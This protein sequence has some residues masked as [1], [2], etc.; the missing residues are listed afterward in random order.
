MQ[1]KDALIWVMRRLV[2][3]PNTVKMTM[4]LPWVPRQARRQATHSID[5]YIRAAEGGAAAL[6]HIRDLELTML[7]TYSNG[8]Q[9]VAWLLRNMSSLKILKLKVKCPEFAGLSFSQLKHLQLDAQVLTESSSFDLGSS[10]PALVS[11]SISGTVRCNIN[12]APCVHLKN[13]KVDGYLHTSEAMKLPAATQLTV[14]MWPGA[15]F[16]KRCESLLSD[17]ASSAICRANQMRINERMFAALDKD[18]ARK[19]VRFLLKD[20]QCLKALTLNLTSPLSLDWMQ[21]CLSVPSMQSLE[22]IIINAPDNW[23]HMEAKLPAVLCK[24]R[25]FVLLT[26]GS[27]YI[28]FEDANS[29]FSTVRSF[30]CIGLPLNGDLDMSRINSTLQSDGLKL[31]IVEVGEEV[32]ASEEEAAALHMYPA[33]CMCLYLHPTGTAPLH[34]G[35]LYDMVKQLAREC[36]CGAC[37]ACLQRAGNIER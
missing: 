20:A 17:Q 33:N 12:A 4:E 18:L 9:F 3:V 25:K 13:F 32:G 5:P 7:D 10:M 22:T 16:I 21:S 2:S 37:F 35:A 6:A 30:H 31:S 34:I 8:A 19:C 27:L 23:A 36:R 24:L 29:T 14:A 1:G 11:L 28:S 15:T 26:R